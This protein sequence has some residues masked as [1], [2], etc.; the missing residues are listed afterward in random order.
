MYAKQTPENF[1]EMIE[2][3]TADYKKYEQSFGWK[4]KSASHSFGDVEKFFITSGDMSC[5]I[6]YDT[7]SKYMRVTNLTSSDTK[8]LASLTEGLK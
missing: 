8:I 7:T 4:F 3:V 1:Q 6:T 5:I 2:K